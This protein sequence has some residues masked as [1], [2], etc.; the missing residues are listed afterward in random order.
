M[1]II[2]IYKKMTM[3]SNIKIKIKILFSFLLFCF[4]S[5]I[6]TAQNSS[7]IV[8]G[9]V[10]DQYGKPVQG[11]TIF[12]TNGGSHTI[13]NVDGEYKLIVN[14]GSKSISCTFIGYKKV[15]IPVK[16]N[17]DNDIH[18]EVVSHNADEL[19]QLGYTS[20]T[21][22]ALGGAVSAI[23]GLELEKSPVASLTQT[24]AGRFSGLTTQETY[25]EPSRTET[26][27]FVRGLNAARAN[28]PIVV[29]D[30]I[31]YT[32]LESETLDYISS[33]EIESVSV[34]KDASTEAIYGIAG[35][36]GVIVI[37]TKRGRPEALKVSAKYDQSVQQ[38]TTKPT[39]YSSADYAVMRNEAAYN[40][41]EGLNYFYDD[42]EIEFFRS[43]EY[44]DLYPNN[45]WYREYMKDLTTQE[46]LGV[47][48]TGGNDKAQFFSNL[49]VLYQGGMFK[50]DQK[51]YDTNNRDIWVNYR[52]NVD[53]NITN[54]LSTFINLSGNI[55]RERTPGA[56]VSSVYSSIFNLPPTMYGPVT[57]RVVD[58]NTGEVM[59]EGG[60]VITT[61]LVA[62]PTYGLLN[63]SGYIR[64]TVTNINS[65]VG[66]KA[67]LSFLTEGLSFSGVFAYQT[68]SVGSLSTLQNY[69]RYERTTSKTKL[70]FTKKGADTN[71]TLAYSKSSMYYHNLSYKTSLDYKRTFGQHD[72][73]AM[74][75]TYYQTLSKSATASP[76][77]LPYNKFFSGVEAIYG[78]ANRYFLKF[79]AGYSG[80]EQYA[81]GH[82]Y[83]FTP[84]VAGTWIIS[85]ERFMNNVPNISYL[86]IR[87]S[88]GKTGNFESGLGRYSYL[89]N[90][91]L[92]GSSSIAYLQYTI[93]EGMVANKDV[94]AE[95]CSKYNVGFDFGLF[96]EL[97]LSVDI[98]K[99]NMDNMIVSAV[100]TVPLYQG[101]ELVNYPSTN[102]GKVENKG[103]EV[104][105]DYTKNIKKDLSFSLGG[106]LSFARNRVIDC[107]EAIKDNDYAYQHRIEGYAYGQ[108]FGYLVDYSNGNG[109][110]NSTEELLTSNL[111]YDFG[112]PRVGDLIYKDLNGDHVINE[113]DQAP[114]GKGAL[115]E[116]TYSFNGNVKFKTVELSFLFQGIDNYSSIYS[117]MGVYETSY[118][119]VYG[120]LHSHAWTQHRYESGE[121]ITAPALSLMESTSHQASD[122][123]NYNRT[124][125]RLRNVELSYTLPKSVSR[126]IAMDNIR[127]ALSGQNLLTW[128]HM[129]SDDF[130]PEHGYSDIPVYRVY[131]L[132]V[133]LNF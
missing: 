35:A 44:S 94:E 52:T 24:F 95:I 109:F 21:R 58:E 13:T 20:Q 130:G 93:N 46:R 32:Y 132:G 80:C 4:L 42:S 110:F 65:H 56:S 49:N 90:V 2:W 14:D 9:E 75:Y 66:C 12:S 22:E 101:V 70:E 26:G 15:E 27:L 125:F 28:G 105:L 57:P 55:K 129:K 29:I 117:G 17:Y 33:E 98:F 38:V 36:N 25:S 50:P 5:M 102:A 123:Y 114:I 115:P 128:D 91:S 10:L 51:E 53:M 45:N 99:E 100:S 124:Y 133:S 103:F 131:N 118:S 127:V 63:R 87:G 43:G 64:H 121:E 19:V 76:E 73:T 23:K 122:Y 78:Y 61:D 41:G 72:V 1:K 113:K 68:N 108:S 40:D 8:Y 84:A 16:E 119:G 39:M 59:D 82:R 69:E 104:S 54:F 71:T 86:K 60:E 37:T 62:S 88:Y 30:G 81:R 7:V 111:L 48:A 47:N 6:V 92:T 34:L 85:N 18:L 97:S 67:D 79:D 31:V 120:A 116:F 74:A 107:K 11:A 126:A 83:L 3:R 89:D 106:M 112:T 96:K 77:C